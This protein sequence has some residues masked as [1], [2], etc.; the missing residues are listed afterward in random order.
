MASK[1][2][3][4]RTTS[5]ATAE[6]EEEAEE[7]T[8]LSNSDVVTKYRLAA[9]IANNTLN[10]VLEQIKPGAK[11]VDICKFG[12]TLIERQCGQSF[13]SKK[14]EKGIAF[15]T[16][17]SVNECVCHFSPL[18][19]ED[20]ELK[21]G[22]VVKVDLG[23]HID[24]YIGVVAHTV[25]VSDKPAAEME[26]LTGEQAKVFKAAHQAAELCARAVKPGEE[27]HTITKMIERVA[28]AYGVTATQAT[29]S[30]Q[31]KQYVSM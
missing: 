13:K 9:D 4:E 21:A 20:Q 16:S 31:L 19:D 24:G 30:H 18:P 29:L 26:P 17:L 11:V 1:T 14:I 6:E 15:P 2:T 10:G 25:V 7:I 3:K 28:E 8:D 22:D 12:D 5:A 23:A 27:N